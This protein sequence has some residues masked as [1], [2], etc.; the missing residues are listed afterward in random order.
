MASRMCAADSDAANSHAANMPAN[1]LGSMI[2][3]FQALHSRRYTQSVSKSW[4]MAVG[5]M[6][7]AAC[8]GDTN[9][10][11]SGSAITPSPKKP[12]FDTP[13]MVTPSSAAATN[14]GSDRSCMRAGH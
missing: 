3:R 4:A 10:D 1:M 2:L 7:A 5:R 9:S 12:P 14:Q 8:N 6:M 13:S 11:I